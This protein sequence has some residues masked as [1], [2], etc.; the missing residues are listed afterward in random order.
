MNVLKLIRDKQVKAQKLREAQ[1]NMAEQHTCYI[2]R[3]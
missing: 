2:V 3:K 1:K